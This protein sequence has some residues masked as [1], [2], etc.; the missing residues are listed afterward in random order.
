MRGLSLRRQLRLGAKKKHSSE[1][2]A[3]GPLRTE[4]YIALVLSAQHVGIWGR[5]D[6]LKPNP[7]LLR[8][9]LYGVV[10]YVL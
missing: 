9:F 4:Y 10:V 8:V 7:Q 2:I 1:E 3:D 6:S 5:C